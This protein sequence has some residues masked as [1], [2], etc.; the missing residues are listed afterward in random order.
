MA[1]ASMPSNSGITPI[2]SDVEA[3]IINDYFVN[4]IRNQSINFWYKTYLNNYLTIKDL[5]FLHSFIL[6][7]IIDIEIKAI[8]EQEKIKK[9]KFYDFFLFF[10]NTIQSYKVNILGEKKKIK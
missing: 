7:N 9:D 4:L 3:E 1:S 8:T 6:K 10:D 5:D 2:F